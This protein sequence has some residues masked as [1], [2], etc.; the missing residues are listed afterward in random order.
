MPHGRIDP[1]TT[2]NLGYMHGGVESTNVVAERCRLL[3]EVRSV[4]A[5]RAD[6]VL[7]RMIDAL[8]DG[9]SHGECDVDFTTEKQ[10]TRSDNRRPER[11]DLE[12]VGAI[13]YPA[14]AGRLK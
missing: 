5:E 11:N 7:A 8:H 13:R 3:A 12:D 2:A 6:E 4:D 10:V 1:Q 14:A 9:A